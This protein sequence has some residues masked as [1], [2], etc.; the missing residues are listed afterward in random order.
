[1][2]IQSEG[3]STKGPDYQQ[4]TRD[5]THSADRVGTG[6]TSNT[7][8]TEGPVEG[9]GSQQSGQQTSQPGAMPPSQTDD[10]QYDQGTVQREA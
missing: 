10:D 3:K 4:S 6:G 8:A 9:K 1:M 2:A 7:G 5:D